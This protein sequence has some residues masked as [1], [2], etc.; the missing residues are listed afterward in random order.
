M[1]SI[2]VILAPLRVYLAGWAL[3]LRGAWAVLRWGWPG[4]AHVLLVALVAGAGF[5]A[6]A[7]WHM[8]AMGAAE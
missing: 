2:H 3:I 4:L 6:G 7:Q 5:V 8:S 1:T